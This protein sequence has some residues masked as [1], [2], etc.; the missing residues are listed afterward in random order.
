MGEAA[1]RLARALGY[2]SAGTVEF[3]LDDETGEFFFLE[4]NTRLQVEHPVTE[5]VTGFD[6][7]KEQIR[8]AAGE[9]IMLNLSGN[10]LRGHAIECRVNAEDP[11]NGFRPNPGKITTFH[12]PGGLGVRVDTH[13]YSGYTVPPFYDSLIAKLI[14]RARNRD[15]AIARAR[16]ALEM[17]VIEGIHTTIPFLR[18]VLDDKEFRSGDIDTH[19]LDRFVAPPLKSVGAR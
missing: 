7:V 16:L 5:L 13:V 9:P 11:E 6:L 8:V 1:L 12:P 4:V 15:E 14:V 18:K 3:L 2:R 17:F 10:R 19:F